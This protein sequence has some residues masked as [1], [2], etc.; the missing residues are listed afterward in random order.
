M[1]YLDDY[2]LFGCPESPEC[3]QALHTA[4]S[5]CKNLG[6]P[7]S[8]SKIEGPAT[9]IT[10]LG[11]VLDT[12]KRELRLPEDK[13]V[14]VIARLEPQKVSYEARV[15]LVDW[16]LAACV[17]SSTSRPDLLTSDDRLCNSGKGTSS[18]HTPYSKFQI[19]SAMVAGLSHKVE[20]CGIDGS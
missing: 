9:T 7:V 12:E 5:L 4:L 15:A 18:P 1:H 2:L 11:I 8:S 17:Q 14:S 6:V 10:F 3:A 19:G 16:T 13:L 20:R